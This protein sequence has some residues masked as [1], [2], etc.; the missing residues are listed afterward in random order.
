VY[1]LLMDTDELVLMDAVQKSLFTVTLSTS[2]EHELLNGQK[3]VTIF[4]TDRKPILT[5]ENNGQTQ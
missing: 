2:I 1:Q 3:V 5:L 4:A